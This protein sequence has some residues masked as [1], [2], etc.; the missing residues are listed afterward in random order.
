MDLVIKRAASLQ[1]QLRPPSDK[2]LTHRA[3]MLGA[4]A[5]GSSRIVNP[6]ISQDC[7]HTL[8]CL[9][10]MGLKFERVSAG[11]ILLHPCQTLTQPA[12]DL[13]CGNS[14]TTMRLLSGL[15]A[16]YPVEATLTGDESLSKRPMG[17][18]AV[19]L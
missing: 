4:L 14:G 3:Y 18:I 6:L 11:E 19:P 15:I 9:A 13:Y 5:E 8:N 2:S 10:Q 16:S 7:E 12:G 1:G 17:R